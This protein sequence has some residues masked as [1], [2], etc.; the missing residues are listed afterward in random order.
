MSSPDGDPLLAVYFLAEKLG[1]SPG[2][3]RTM[4]TSEFNGWTAY[5]NH[6]APQ[7]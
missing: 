6:K 3:I 2:E 1:R 5:F 7:K 4:S